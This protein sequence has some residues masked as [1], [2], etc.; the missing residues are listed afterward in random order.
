M[1]LDG[2]LRE[3]LFLRGQRWDEAVYSILR[4]ELD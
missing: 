3:S 1:T 2:V 4:G